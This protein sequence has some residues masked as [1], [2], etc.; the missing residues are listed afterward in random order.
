MD[1]LQKYVNEALGIELK[2]FTFPKNERNELPLYLRNNS[3]KIGEIFQRQIIFNTISAETNFTVDQYR[4]LAD[5]I[6]NKLG[7]PVVFVFENIEAY[8][9]KRLIQKNVAFIIPGKQMYLPFMFIE[10]K[11]LKQIHARKVEKLFPAA[12]SLLLY[13]LLGNELTGINFKTLAEKLNYGPMTV[14]RV[15]NTLMDLEL[16][17]IVGGKDKSLIFDKGKAQLWNEVQPYLIN[18]VKKLVFVEHLKNFEHI[19]ITDIPAL[20]NYT[21]IADN[22]KPS[23]A[24]SMKAFNV[25]QKKKTIH[26]A[27][28]TE[29]DMM[30]QIW[31]YD[32]GNLTSNR[33]VD[34]L[35]LYLTL[36]DSKDERIE[37]ELKILLNK[38]W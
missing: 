28:R 30:L 8:N 26:I 7:M 6:E 36:K 19:F 22:G 5:I 13:Y 1:K 35:S 15:V 38:L 17:R 9:R 10:L 27:G 18:P 29:G 24:M 4:K 34:P 31:K 21:N 33:Y 12:Q 2:L 25:L 32:P 16:C 37:G 3:L 20:S 14:T 11:E 23:F